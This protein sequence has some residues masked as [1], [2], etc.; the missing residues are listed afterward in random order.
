[1]EEIPKGRACRNRSGRSENHKT[2]V[3]VCVESESR[4]TER[5]IKKKTSGIERTS[6][7]VISRLDLKLNTVK[8]H[9]FGWNKIY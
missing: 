4:T 8:I 3:H 6:V 9:E 7:Y 2:I 5:K 1:M